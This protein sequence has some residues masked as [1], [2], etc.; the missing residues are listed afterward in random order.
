MDH[1]APPEAALTG[2]VSGR[3]KTLAEAKLWMKAK[4]AAR[5]HPMIALPHDRA[6]A[7]IDAL[8]GLDPLNWTAVWRPVGDAARIAAQAAEA[9]GRTADAERLYREASGL[10]FMGRFPSPTHVAEQECAVL[11]R[12]TYLAAARLWDRPIEPIVIPFAGHAGE[13]DRVVVYLR[14]PLGIPRPPVV[15]MWGGVDAWKKQVTAVSDAL[16]AQGFA[17]IA[18]DNAGTGESPLRGT[19]DGER[20]FVAVLDWAAAQGDLTGERC[21]LLG[22]SFGGYWVTK[23]VHQIPDRIVCG[24]NWG[25]GA[26][27]MFQRDWIEA[28]RF[29]DSYLMD[30]VETRMAMLGATDDQGYIDG[31]ARLSLVDQRLLDRPCAPLLL[32][33]GKNDQQCPIA[34]IHLLSEHGSPKAV[35]LFPGGHMGNTQQ[36]LPTIVTWIA[37]HF[38]EALA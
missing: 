19:V 30:L 2:N 20:A 15:L 36:T 33:N 27:F 37:S 16:L 9:E 31:F 23:L 3:P 18:M 13:G 8:E 35:R 24:V 34:D 17:T 5:A 29:P 22:R 10:Y 6:D 25:G 4:V 38:V 28:S 21:A 32:M 26:H 1:P 14:R 7:L 11:E 12:E